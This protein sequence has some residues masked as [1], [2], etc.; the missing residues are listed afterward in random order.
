MSKRRKRY[1]S[2]GRVTTRS[3]SAG[4][5]ARRRRRVT[6]AMAGVAVVVMLILSA[7]AGPSLLFGT[8]TP[9]GPAATATDQPLI[10]LP[11]GQPFA[12]IAP[13]Q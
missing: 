7:M 11:S 9:P 8:G 2:L 1:R 13:L 6:L 10:V 4:G 12:T 3:T 5:A